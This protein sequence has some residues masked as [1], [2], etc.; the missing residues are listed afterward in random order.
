MIVLDTDH[1]SL[2]QHRDSPR[3][4]VLRQRVLALPTD[5]VAVT[6]ATVEEQARSWISLIGRYSDVRQQVAYYARFVAMFR[7]F[8]TWQ[9]L[10]FDQRAA[11]EFRRLRSERV[12]IGATG[13][14]IAAI[15]LVHAATPVSGNLRDFDRVFGLRVENWLP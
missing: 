15:T 10:P 6:A 3:A 12:R 7:F 1:I 2:L 13:L 9:I 14:K 8:A 4:E 5:E 11:E